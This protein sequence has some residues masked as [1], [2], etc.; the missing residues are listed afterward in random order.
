MFGINWIQKIVTGLQ[1]GTDQTITFANSASANTQVT[2]D[3]SKPNNPKD[4]YMVTVYNPSVVTDLTVK[5]FAKAPSLGGGDRYSLI[6]W[7]SVPKSQ[8][9]TGTTVNCYSKLFQ[10]LF[11][12]TDIRVVISNDIVLGGSDGFDATLRVR[13]A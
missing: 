10:G 6:D 11:V 9:I 5:V 13:E 3:I 8:S 4:G 12:G 1:I 7:F 2:K